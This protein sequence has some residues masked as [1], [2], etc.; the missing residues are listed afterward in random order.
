MRPNTSL[1]PHHALLAVAVLWLGGC[2]HTPFT[3]LPGFAEL[4]LARGGEP[5]GAAERG[6]LERFK[7]QLFIAEGAEGPIDFYRDYIAY[8]RLRDG[9]GGEHPPDRDALNRLRADPDAVFV[10][11][12]PDDA[13]AHPVAY[14]GFRRAELMLD[15]ERRIPIDVLSYHFVFRHSGL[16]R[17]APA[18]L[19]YLA[20]LVG[21]DR[22]WHQLDHYTAAFVILNE[23]GQ[24]FAVM[25]QQH[26]YL[27]TYLV[28]SDPALPAGGPIQLDSAID[29]NELY[30]HRAELTSR[31]AAGFMGA[32]VADYLAGVS[33]DPPFLLAAPDLT[34]GRHRVDYELEF[35]PPN[36]AFYVFE[37]R[38][39][40]PRRLPGRDGPPGAM[41]N[42]L[43]ALQL[44]E[45]ALPLFYWQPPDAEFAELVKDEDENGVPSAAARQRLRL[46][47]STALAD[48][49]GH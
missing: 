2:G 11:R 23:S 25:L 47:F 5:P 17:G 20:G 14:G 33:E 21:A 3:Q 9:A 32:Q 8:G 1:R 42:T 48:V 24:A 13:P 7:P 39:G 43:P 4:R 38:L 22:D 44:P 36:D 18:V 34:H 6:L 27:R 41:Y 46:R 10:H 12:P 29:S 16:P 45:T 19:R 26:N 35:L 28:G 30:P 15:A 31:P 49:G 37:G 40:E